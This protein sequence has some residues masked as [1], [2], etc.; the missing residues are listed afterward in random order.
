MHDPRLT[1]ARGDI[2]AKYLEGKVEAAH[3]VEGEVFEIVDAVAPLRRSP[4]S[5]AEL[6]TQALRGER[7]TI[8]DRNAEGWAWGQLDSDGFPMRRSQSRARRRPIASPRSGH[9]PLADH[10]SSCRLSRRW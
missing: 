7:V 4:G 3:F 10:R 9:S 8:Y 6:M 2:A 1:A 5:D